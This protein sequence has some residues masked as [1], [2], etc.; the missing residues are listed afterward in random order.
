MR[1][2]TR[3]ENLMQEIQTLR[4]RLNDLVEEGGRLRGDEAIQ[5]SYKLDQLIAEFLRLQE[6]SNAG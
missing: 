4:L 3:L 5:V 2:E 1:L 6:K